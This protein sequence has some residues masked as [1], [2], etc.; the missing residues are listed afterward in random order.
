M[1]ETLLIVGIKKLGREIALHFARQGWNVVCAARTAADVEAL[2]AD[3]GRAGGR[4]IPFVCDITER[5]TL[6]PLSQWEIDLAVA[7]QSPGG[8][9]GKKPLLELE[10]EELVKGFSTSVQGTWNLLQAV[11]PHF[12]QR[13]RGTFIQIGTSSG[14]RTKDG[15][16]ALGTNQFALR[17]LVQVAAKEWREHGVHVA[18]VPIDGPIES[19]LSRQWTAQAGPDATVPPAEIAK[20]CEYLHRQAPRAFTH[21]LVL[22]PRIG[23]WTAPT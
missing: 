20:A 14:M 13:G 16:A 17:A 10:D 2:A 5:A 23:E 9:F 8:R 1:A 18:Y 7:S 15:F 21:E 3:V 11:G 12:V 4:G 19:E 6:A 22:R